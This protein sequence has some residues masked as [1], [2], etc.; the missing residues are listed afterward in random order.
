MQSSTVPKS[1]VRSGTVQQSEQLLVRYSRYSLTESSTAWCSPGH[2]R[3][4][5]H[6]PSPEP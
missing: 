5:V 6:N 4:G 3:T 2:S 1:T